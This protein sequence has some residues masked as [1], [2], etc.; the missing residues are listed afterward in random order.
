MFIELKKAFLVEKPSDLFIKIS[1][2]SSIAGCE[3][4]SRDMNNIVHRTDR[5]GRQYAIA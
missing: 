4:D 3:R 5:R 1:S 2:L